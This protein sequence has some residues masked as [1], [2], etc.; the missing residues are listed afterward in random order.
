M[1]CFGARA[2]ILGMAEPIQLDLFSGR[3]A[4]RE[5]P[6]EPRAAGRPPADLS[7]GE[8]VAALV[9]R[10]IDETSALAAEAGRR[11]LA[12]AVATLARLCRRFV[13]FGLEKLVPEQAA[14]LDALATIGGRD[15]RH[16]VERLIA[17]GIVQGPNL[18]TAVAAA[19]RLGCNFPPELGI[20]LLRNPDPSVRAS[21]CAGIR[22]SGNVVDVLKALL[23]DRDREV[24]IAAA[25]ALGRAGHVDALPALKNRLREAPSNRVIEALAGVADED[26][27][28]FLR[29]A[30]LERPEFSASVVAALQEI[31][32]PS[33]V[34]AADALRAR[35]A[36][37]PRGPLTPSNTAPATRDPPPPACRSPPA[38]DA[39]RDRAESAG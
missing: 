5:G 6:I 17:E 7:D 18:A 23:H 20:L 25:C 37:E 19:A 1:K 29:R 27:V 12:D 34:R 24:S 3:S 33:A 11:G 38:L 31:D 39:S 15:A 21:A 16:E 26:A 13:G 2:K 14:A 32:L 8:L 28:V 9:D 30:G 4:I 10:G 36:A 22:P 35:S